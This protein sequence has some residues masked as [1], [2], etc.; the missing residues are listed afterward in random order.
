MKAIV[1]T[2]YG[3]PDVLHLKEVEKPV[4]EDNEILIKNYA[5]SVSSGDWHMRKADPF[6]VRLFAGLTKPKNRILGVVLAGEIEAVGENVKKFK[7]GDK[8]FGA[9]G[10]SMGSYAEYICLSED[11]VVAVKP[12]NMTYEEAVS[13]PFGG[14][15]ALYFLRKANIQKGQNILIYGA[16]GAVGTAAVQLAKHYGAFVTGVCSTSNIDLVKSLG[17]DKVIDYTKED[18]SS[19]DE[20][21]DVIFD[22]VGKSSFSWSIKSLKKKGFL[23]LAAAGPSQMIRGVWSSLTSSKTVVSGIMSETAE[24]L[25]FFKELIEAEKF[26][27]VID[28]RY[29]LEETSEAHRYV[30]QGHKKGN[31]VITIKQEKKNEIGQ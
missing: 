19:S 26:K 25:I 10:M 1:Y 24:D 7:P 18:I 17:A 30:E 2:E 15:T 12:D 14:N 22:T 11:A 28:R 23:L 16:S 3:T 9:T 27:P 4:P 13:V 31:V 5:T 8:I 29:P 20:V 21:Y 6:I